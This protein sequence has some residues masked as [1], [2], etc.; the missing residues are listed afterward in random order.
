MESLKQRTL[1]GLTWASVSQVTKLVTQFS[2]TA[3]LARLLEPSDFGLLGMANIFI[4]LGTLLNERGFSSALIQNKEV[5]DKHYSTVFWINVA[6]GLFLMA[7]LHVAIPVIVIFFGR[8]EL[9][10]ILET[11]SIVFVLSSMMVVQR[12]L[13][14]K[15][16]EFKSIAIVDTT[17]F[18]TGGTVGIYLA[19]NNYGVISLVYQSIVQMAVALILFWYFSKWRPHFSFSVDAIKDIY[20]FGIHVTGTEVLGYVS[21]NIDFLLIGKFLG[22]EALGYYTLAFKLM[23][24][25][26]RNIAWMVSQVMYPAYSHIQH[27]IKKLRKHY[28]ITLKAVNL[29]TFPMLFGLFVLAPEFVYSIPGPDW[30]PAILVIRLLCVVGIL[31]VIGFSWSSILLSR[32]RSDL[33]F[34][35]TLIGALTK[36]VFIVAGLP[37]GIYGV[38]ALYAVHQILW[39]PISGSKAL[40]SIHLPIVKVFPVIFRTIMLCMPMV[41]VVT[42]LKLAINIEPLQ[43]LLVFTVSGAI[44]YALVLW[45]GEKRFILNNISKKS[46]RKPSQ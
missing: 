8:D 29:V 43:A 44:I 5:N 30:E 13:L 41:L 21:R 24:V 34:W 4:Y 6:F 40:A 33:Q 12:A 38:T 26:I 2:V 10:V 15:F 25:P 9:V 22:A 7:L 39:V 14:L 36:V 42:S 16:M 18:I 37:W 31:K 32:G 28:L 19:L 27:D 11:L 1:Y 35:L 17:S 45:Y 20:R 3:I 46:V 23:M